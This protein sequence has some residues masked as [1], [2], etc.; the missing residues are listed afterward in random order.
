MKLMVKRLHLAREYRDLT[1]RELSRRSGV[2][3]ASL[4]RIEAG[5]QPLTEKT[6]A[7][8]APVLNVTPEMLRGEVEIEL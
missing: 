2:S 5:L 1:L 4:S 6:I 8:I 3:F 7:K